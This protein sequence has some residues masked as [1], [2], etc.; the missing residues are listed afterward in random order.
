MNFWTPIEDK[1]VLL[2]EAMAAC[3][4]ARLKG[5]RIVFTNG[6]FDI[7]HEGHVR[8]LA[9]AR[10]SGDLLIVGINSSD[11]VRRLK[12]AERPINDEQS[13]ALVLASL[14]FVDLVVLFDS[15][16]PEALIQA[17]RPDTLVKG[18]DW[19][20]EQIVGG[21]FVQSYGGTVL[22]LPFH[23]GFSTTSLVEKIR[24]L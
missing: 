15:D 24:T 6:C 10:S 4:R 17:L 7:L 20:V 12:G 16:T 18:G 22:S 2:K 8:Y 14:T 5:Q 3:A 1:V 19:A 21:A 23:K 11:S 13:R 9:E